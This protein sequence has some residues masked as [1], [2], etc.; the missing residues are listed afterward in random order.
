MKIKTTIYVL[1]FPLFL[2]G[3]DIENI[4]IDNPIVFKGSFSAYGGYASINDGVQ[5]RVSPYTVGVNGR[6][7]LS[8]NGLSVPLYF[9]V[10]DHSYNYGAT[11][12]RLRI[13]PRYKWAELQ[14]GDVYTRFNPYTFSQRNMRG[15]AI[16][17]NPGKFRFQ[18]LYGKMQE[19]RSFQDTLNLGTSDRQVF[20][21]KVMG[22]GIG[23]GKRS[24][25]IDIYALK[26]WTADDSLSFVHASLPR[27]DNLVLGSTGKIKISRSLRAQ[28]NLGIS[29]LTYDLDAIGKQETIVENGL[30]GS[31]LNVNNTSSANYAG[32]VSLSYTR[33]KYG[34]NGKVSYIQAF[35][36]PLTV[37][38]INNDV[39][40][41]TI[42]SFVSLWKNKL[43]LKGNIGIQQNNLSGV[44]NFTTDRVIYNIL[45]NIRLAKGLNANIVHNN[46]SQS[47]QVRLINIEHQY[48]YALDN[49]TSTI[50]L[51]HQHEGDR[52]GYTNNISIGNNNLTSASDDAEE[53]TTFDM[54]YGRWDGS[55]TFVESDFSITS[56]INYTRYNNAENNIN[57]GLSLGLR[58]SFFDKKLMLT[59]Q[60][61]FNYLDQDDYREGTSLI[62][63]LNARYQVKK[64]T[65]LLLTLMRINRQSNLKNQFTE[66]RS[67]ISIQQSF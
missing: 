41:Y 62:N 67:R 26:S 14:I 3:Q 30:T 16:K 19:L 39:L 59:A 27:Q 43:Y 49:T 36:Q 58:K 13:N 47:L 55:F 48:T 20:S 24:N 22:L 61:T 11:L 54:L 28:Y 1:L 18:A 31:L 64:K 35:Y 5:D 25:F 52:Y 9:A 15:L 44:D 45:A 38:F 60:N 6:I 51:S 57:Y 32:D 50:S 40:N 2:I 23:F 17:L 8:W 33:G 7:S 34:I 21:N 56:G 4:K 65:N 12:P 46:F 66:N 42:G 53:A 29:A 37:A 63:T 10:R